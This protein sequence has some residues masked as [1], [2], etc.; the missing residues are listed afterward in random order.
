MKYIFILVLCLQLQLYATE[1][2]HEVSKANISWGENLNLTLDENGFSTTTK[3]LRVFGS[4]SLKDEDFRSILL[5]KNLRFPKHNMIL[6]RHNY[7]I[8]ILDLNKEEMIGEFKIPSRGTPSFIKIEP[9]ENG[10]TSLKTSFNI[11][12]KEPSDKKQPIGRPGPRITT[13]MIYKDG[14]YIHLKK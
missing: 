5:Y 2:S 14:K 4:F 7:T 11:L 13:I 8:Y 12:P 1:H 3:G 10:Y 9:N 6:V